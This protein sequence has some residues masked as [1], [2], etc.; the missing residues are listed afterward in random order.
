MLESDLEHALVLQIEKFLLELGRGFMFVGTQQRVTINNTHY[1]V[2][3]VFYNKILKAYV[4][5][6]LKTTKLTPEAAGQINM[7]LNYYAAEYALG[8][9]SN[10]IFASRYV[11]YIPNKEQLIAQVESVLQRWHEVKKT[12]NT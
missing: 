11:L 9:L 3:M 4:L 8:G 5:I 1:Y 10:N 2:D 12:E 7:Y 6:E